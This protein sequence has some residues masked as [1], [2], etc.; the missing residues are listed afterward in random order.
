MAA[1][2]APQPS[3]KTLSKTLMEMK[4]MRRKAE[5]DYR[6]QL[7]EERQRAIEESHWVLDEKE[8]D[9]RS[10]IEFEPSYVK[11]EELYPSGRMSFK[12]FNPTVEVS[13][14]V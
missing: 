6:R 4:F 2:V 8:K 12:N 7:E 3:K 1:E 10:C 9:D 13:L 14:N 5:S 11:C